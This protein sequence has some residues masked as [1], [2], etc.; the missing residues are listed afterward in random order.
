VKEEQDLYWNLVF[1]FKY[2]GL[3]YLWLAPFIHHFPGPV[4]DQSASNE[5]AAPQKV[6][7]CFTSSIDMFKYHFGEDI[8]PKLN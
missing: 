7:D 1:W 6:P 8:A 3:P 2:I 4:V 5:Q